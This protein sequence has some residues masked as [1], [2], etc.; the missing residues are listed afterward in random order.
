MIKLTS[1]SLHLLALSSTPQPISSASQSPTITSPN[2]LSPTS[3]PVEFSNIT[4]YNDG[5][6]HIIQ[7]NS[8]SEE[9]FVV[10]DKT[11]LELQEGGVISAPS[12]SEWPAIRLSIGSVLNATGGSVT[13]STGVVDGGT[14]IQLNNG[15]SSSATAGY[16]QFYDGVQVVGGDASSGIGGDALIVNGFGTEAILYGGEFVG[17]SGTESDGNSIRVLNSATVQI[18][19]GSFTGD[20]M[21]DG[22]GLIALHGCF[23]FNGTQI[24]GIFADDSEFNVNIKSESGGSID[25]VSVPEQECETAPSVAPTSFPTV[26]SRPTVQTSS[27]DSSVITI[28]CVFAFVSILGVAQHL[29]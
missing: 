28:S 24:V 22:N 21:V 19:G 29:L 26:S 11:T 17:G 4:L 18:H 13:G 23:S 20:M 12:N 15:Q 8:H 7:D 5:S 16:A 27:G 25:F 2:E 6:T 9:V 10:T 3:S 14:A 1:L